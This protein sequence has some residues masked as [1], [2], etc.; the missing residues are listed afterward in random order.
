MGQHQ[1]LTARVQQSRPGQP[2]PS[3]E[4][5]PASCTCRAHPLPAT[6][7][8]RDGLNVYLAENGFTT[9]SY[10]GSTTEG[11]FLGWKFAVPNPPSHQ[12]AIRLH[13]LHHVATGFGTDLVGEGEISAWQAR[14]G[15]RGAGTYVAAIVFGNALL[16]IVFAPRRTTLALR[17]PHAG[18]S[19]FSASIDYPSLLDR[20]VGELREMLAIPAR[21]L[22]TL[23]R[24]LHAHA[25]RSL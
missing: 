13:D 18:G 25:P 23:P 12:R 5:H 24:A 7:R 15:L 3:G 11:S 17:G 10:D 14:R 1:R 19:L 2:A 8:V 6:M 21:G 20:T 9:K 16:G 4:D 22:A